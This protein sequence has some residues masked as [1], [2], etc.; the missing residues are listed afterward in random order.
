MDKGLSL[1]VKGKAAFERDSV[2][3]YEHEYSKHL[4]DV[5]LKIAKEHKNHLNLVD[6]GGALGSIYF[7]YKSLLKGVE[8]NWSVVEQ[9]DFV[10]LGRKKYTNSQLSFFGTIEEALNKCPH[11]VLLLS[12]VLAYLEK[13]EELLDH[14]KKLKFEYIILYRTAFVQRNTN[15]LTVQHVPP[16]VYKA[17]Y[18]SWFLSEKRILDLLSS[19]YLVQSSFSGDIETKLVVNGNN[20]YWKGIV[21]KLK[22]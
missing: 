4:L 3:F 22:K 12:S 15:L 19:E 17:T 11:E 16:E 1:V 7:Q 10:K 13:P 20:C 21:F 9:P 18:P 2:V 5:F 6:F 8:L 14:V